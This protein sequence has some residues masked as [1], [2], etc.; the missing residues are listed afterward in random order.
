MARLFDEIEPKLAEWIGRQP[1]FFV[2]TA[3]SGSD[4]HVNVSPKA[5]GETLRILGPRTVAY[6]DFVGSG[7]ETVSHLRENGRIVIMLCAFTGP[8]RIVRLHGRGRVVAL[9]DPEFAELSAPFGLEPGTFEDKVARSVVLVDVD[10]IADSCG[11][12]VP[13]MDLVGRRTQLEGWAESRLR[14]DPDGIRTYV[15][16]RNARSIDGLPGLEP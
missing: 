12:G 6:L 10:R 9:R 7:I 2:G 13:L 15:R 14:N 5:P 16:E 3:P 8:P 11:Y 1:V 4:G